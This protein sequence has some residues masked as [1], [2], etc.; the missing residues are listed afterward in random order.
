MSWDLRREKGTYAEPTQVGIYEAATEEG[1]SMTRTP[2]TEGPPPAIC[3][4][5]G[6][7]VRQRGIVLE[8]QGR[9]AS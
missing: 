4:Q 1:V 7:K 9:V 5:A 8:D 3:L 6:N 2:L